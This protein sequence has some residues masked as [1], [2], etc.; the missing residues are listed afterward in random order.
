MASAKFYLHEYKAILSVLLII[1]CL[2]LMAMS[3]FGYPDKDGNTGS[4]PLA[5]L[6]GLNSIVIL[7]MIIF[8]IVGLYIFYRYASDK[9]KFESLMNTRSQAIFK[10]NQLEIE[11]LALRLTSREERR[12]IEAMKKYKIK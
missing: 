9:T 8:I 10:K 7:F 12:V 4:G 6:K 5:S 3:I 11:R 1:G 2:S